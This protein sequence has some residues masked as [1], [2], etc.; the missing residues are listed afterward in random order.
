MVFGRLKMFIGFQC[1]GPKV[2]VRVCSFLG[3]VHFSTTVPK[4]RSLHHCSILPLLL[5]ILAGRLVG[6]WSGALQV[7]PCFRKFVMILFS[8][9]SIGSKNW[10]NLYD[11]YY[12]I[13]T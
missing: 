3:F 13:H 12:K 4:A 10:T 11:R 2:E 5:A 9:C 7:Q 8:E 6:R 1:R